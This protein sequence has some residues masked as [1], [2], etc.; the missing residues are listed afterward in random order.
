M[1]RKKRAR[2]IKIEQTRAPTKAKFAWYV[3]NEILWKTRGRSSRPYTISSLLAAYSDEETG[4]LHPTISIE[5]LAATHRCTAQTIKNNLKKL[6]DLGIV[7][8]AP[9]G[10]PV[11]LLFDTKVPEESE[12]TDK[13]TTS[14]VIEMPQIPTREE[15]WA[16]GIVIVRDPGDPEPI[17][18]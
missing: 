12:S 9:D 1:P 7:E 10:S 14:K 6:A 11:R 16:S 8:I 3:P 4:Y 18:R 5:R 15:Y 2:I 17:D 13:I